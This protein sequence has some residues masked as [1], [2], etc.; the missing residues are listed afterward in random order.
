MEKYMHDYAKR[1]GFCCECIEGT[2]EG[3]FDGAIVVLGSKMDIAIC[4]QV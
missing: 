3:S 1:E 4:Q 2:F